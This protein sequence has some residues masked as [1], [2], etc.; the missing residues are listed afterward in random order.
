MGKNN[1]QLSQ[2]IE[3]TLMQNGKN[4][5]ETEFKGKAATLNTSHS[6]PHVLAMILRFLK[7]SNSMSILWKQ[8]HHIVRKACARLVQTHLLFP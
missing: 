8:L 3:Q 1:T 5:D 2:A 7:T 4:A 6:D